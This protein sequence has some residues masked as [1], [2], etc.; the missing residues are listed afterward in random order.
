[1]ANLQRNHD[2]TSRMRT[3]MHP[4]QHLD[5]QDSLRQKKGQQ[6]HAGVTERPKDGQPV[7]L[8]PGVQSTL[9]SSRSLEIKP[10][11][12]DSTLDVKS[13]T[14]FS[15]LRSTYRDIRRAAALKMEGKSSKTRVKPNTR[16]SRSKQVGLV[17]LSPILDARSGELPI[18]GGIVTPAQK[19]LSQDKK[20]GQS[21]QSGSESSPVSAVTSTSQTG[22]VY[23]SSEPPQQP[24]RRV[25]NDV[26]PERPHI[27]HPGS[28]EHSKDY[29][30]HEKRAQTA[31][32]LASVQTTHAFGENTEEVP[33]IGNLGDLRE[34]SSTQSPITELWYAS[35]ALPSGDEPNRTQH[36]RKDPLA[37]V[38]TRASPGLKSAPLKSEQPSLNKEVLAG[39]PTATGTTMSQGPDLSQRLSSLSIETSTRPQELHTPTAI[40]SVLEHTKAESSSSPQNEQCGSLSQP[41]HLTTTAHC[42]SST[43]LAAQSIEVDVPARYAEY[44]PRKE[45]QDQIRSSYGAQGSPSIL[46]IASTN[47]TVPRNVIALSPLPTGP[48]DTGTDSEQSTCDRT[49]CTSPAQQ[50][51]PSV[52]T[53]SVA[54]VSSTV[55]ASNS[56]TAVS[57]DVAIE[58]SRHKPTRSQA[59][60]DLQSPNVADINLSRPKGGSSESTF[61]PTVI[62]PAA[63]TRDSN[64]P[65]SSPSEAQTRTQDNKLHKV[66]SIYRML[67]RITM[68]VRNGQTLPPNSD[69]SKHFQTAVLLNDR[70]QRLRIPASAMQV[71]C[72]TVEERLFVALAHHLR[73]LLEYA[74]SLLMETT[75]RGKE[76]L[77]CASS[78]EQEVVFFNKLQIWLE[79][80]DGDHTVRH[81]SGQEEFEARINGWWAM[82]KPSNNRS[83][84]INATCEDSSSAEAL[85]AMNQPNKDIFAP[86]WDFFGIQRS[87][88]ANAPP[89][90]SSQPSRDQKPPQL[91]CSLHSTSAASNAAPSK[92]V[93]KKPVRIGTKSTAATPIKASKPAPRQAQHQPQLQGKSK[94]LS[95]MQPTAASRARRNDNATRSII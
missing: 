72:C 11:S 51:V 28:N 26:V 56:H 12:K 16:P 92:S 94:M 38:D 45:A 3:L 53:K 30:I 65:V 89:D 13:E 23:K 1:M 14:P 67:M 39:Y 95:F 84:S 61:T 49:Q 88:Q 73:A 50:V 78:W 70:L 81:W 6:P 79:H 59:Q 9:L 27:W 90:S 60:T 24:R 25:I 91:D 76:D 29:P 47:A 4:Q 82:Q 2:H 42:Q 22:L 75:C 19:L 66:L 35:Q 63:R 5:L 34:P 54:R 64:P 43:E 48:M 21:F 46:E 32:N 58:A 44:Q 83:M 57:T 71:I 80:N 10:F 52:S 87:S 68:E 86:I 74:N 17:S 85:P 7:K 55:T 37:C 40:R 62:E 31:T 15:A 20:Q 36:Y 33:L 18:E 93:I 77:A 8:C 69:V 41:Q